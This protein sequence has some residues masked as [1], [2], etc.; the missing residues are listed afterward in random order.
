M[1]DATFD[2][3]FKSLQ[4]LI[5]SYEKKN[6][7]IKTQSD[8]ESNIV[9]LFGEQMSSLARAQ[10][11]LDDVSELACTVA[12]HHP[13]WNVLYHACQISKITLDKWD[14]EL[15]KEELDEISWSIDELKN[16]CEK[17]KAR[18]QNDHIH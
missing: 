18:P 9:R 3:F 12:E 1:T 10:S 16:T 7:M 8:L 4:E 17:L 5:K 11:G 13:Y 6:L 15:T 2:D 14:G